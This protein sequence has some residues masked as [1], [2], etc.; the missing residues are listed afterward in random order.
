[1]SRPVDGMLIIFDIGK[2]VS[3]V[4]EKSNES[5]FQKARQ[6][7]IRIIEEKIIS[8]S[9]DLVGLVFLGS[10]KTDN[11]LADQCPGSFN[12]IQL[13]PL[14]K[15]DWK[16]IREFPDKPTNKTGD[17]FEAL[18]VS[19]NYYKNQYSGAK[20]ITYKIILVTNFHASALLGSNIEQVVQ[21]FKERFKVIVIGW[22]PSDGNKTDDVLLAKHFVKITQ[23]S[24]ATFE[25]ALNVLLF[26]RKKATKPMPWNVNLSIGPNIKIPVSSYGK[27]RK[28]DQIVGTWQPALKDPVLQELDSDVGVTKKTELINIET[29]MV[30]DVQNTIQGYVYGERVIPFS[31]YDKEMFYK[32]GD[33]CLSIYGFTNAADVKWQNLAGD[34]VSYIFPRPGM[35]TAHTALTCLIKCMIDMNLVAVARRVYNNGNAPIMHVLSPLLEEGC[36]CL[37][38]IAINFK[39]DIK[40]MNFPSTDAAKYSC[41]N[42]QVNAFK[43]LIESMNLMEAYDK[44]YDSREAF[45]TAETV[46]P[47]IQHIFDSI[48]FRALNPEKHVPPPRDDLMVLLNVPPLVEE[49]SRAAL[50]KLKAVLNLKKCSNV[51]IKKNVANVESNILNDDLNSSKVTAPTDIPKVMIPKVKYDVNDIGTLNPVDD[52]KILL[53]KGKAHADLF[54]EIIDVLETMLYIDHENN[55][56]RILDIF[57]FL[58]EECEKTDPEPFNAWFKNFKKDLVENQRDDILKF[59]NVIRVGEDDVA[60]ENE[61]DSQVYQCDTIPDSAE[62]SILTEVRDFFDEM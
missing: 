43:E 46:N 18:L 54:K 37:S 27:T 14:K 60:D 32:S 12:N 52:F 19:A 30:V 44:T 31:K 15:P 59:L 34:G 13:V 7:V 55:S 36:Y 8:K 48:A 20:I 47:S 23:G 17:W 61:V 56:D 39:D 1:M 38:A 24:F 10:D 16:M 42:E 57:A 33:K 11:E 9:T 35:K 21:G 29:N 22:N 62:L 58:K 40:N 26:H 51:I 50:K 53:N 25:E 28:C 2:N 41:N 4:D 3:E 5:F 49:R 6:C 45:P